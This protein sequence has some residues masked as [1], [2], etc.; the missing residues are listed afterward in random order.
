VCGGVQAAAA[1]LIVCHPAPHAQMLALTLALPEPAA[2]AQFDTGAVAVPLQRLA[3]EL[4][5]LVEP[6]VADVGAAPPR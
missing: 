4:R 1:V 5:V 6:V 2:V 3:E